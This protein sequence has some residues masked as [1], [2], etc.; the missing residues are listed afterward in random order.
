METF[1]YE[2]RVLT[3]FKAFSVCR[4]ELYCMKAEFFFLDPVTTE[5]ANIRKSLGF[6]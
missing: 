5:T 4:L 6:Y 1:S 3:G 2:I